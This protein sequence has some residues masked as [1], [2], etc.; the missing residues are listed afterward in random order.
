MEQKRAA[1]ESWSSHQS[2]GPDA[3]LVNK[4]IAAIQRAAMPLPLHP[5]SGCKNTL[6][7][8]NFLNE[9]H[10][11][12]TFAI[13]AHP[14]A[15]KTTLTEKLLLFGG[16]IQTA[17][18]VKS[19]KI[20]K[21]T[22][23]DFMEIERQRGISVSTS[24]MGFEYRGLQINILDT[25]GHEDFAE[26]TYRTLTAVDSAVVVVDA[27]KGVET[28]TE[29]LT[30][31]CRMRTTPIIFFINKLDRE[32]LDPFDLLDEIEQ[33]LSVK[34]RP[35][36]WPIGMG[37]RF[38]GVY[39]LYE[40]RLVLF[41]PHGKQQQEE[42]VVFEDVQD[43]ALEQYL[44]AG[45]AQQLREDVET[46]EVVYPPFDRET[47]LRGDVCPV[48]FGSAV[49]NF[50]VR[51]LLDCFVDIAP[52]PLPRQAAERWVKPEEEKFSGFVFKI[53]ANMDPRHRDRIAFLRVCSGRFERNKNYHHVRLRRDF[54]FPAPTMFMASKKTLLEEAYPGDVVGLYDSGNFKIGDTL[55]EGE[56][57]HFKGIPSFSPEQFRYV[58]NADPLKQKQFAKGLEQLMDEGVAQLF[59]RQSDGRRIVGTV[60]ML[61]FEVLQHRLE[62]EYGAKCRYEPIHLHKACWVSSDDPKA[63][64]EFLERRKRDIAKD[65]HGEWVFLAETAWILK[66]VQE[67]FPK[68]HFRFT[69]EA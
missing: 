44:G 26:D 33:K 13:I 20:K 62:S 35:L 24:V 67:N 50:G 57:L 68:I 12:R 48:F 4:G 34:V 32:G 17:G 55:T 28:Q 23:S 22:V 54:K 64:R 6:P 18:A 36:S 60:G 14:D 9:L 2:R 29:K 42:S 11:R 25:P 3:F 66:T 59:V 10:R 1:Q 39:S 61:Q 16:A 63:L 49:N 47:Y 7:V 27:A 45:A 69:S 37:Q 41:Q 52:L 40:R 53:F 5:F 38:Q 19:N 15:G 21:S 8:S 43:P 56:E 51:E 65:R 31:V 30:Q 58:E 46:I